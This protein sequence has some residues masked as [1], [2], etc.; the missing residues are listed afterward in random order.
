M[1][2]RQNISMETSDIDRLK[3][4][5]GRLTG[6]GVNGLAAALLNMFGDPESPDA[7]HANLCA[8]LSTYDL[9]RVRYKASDDEL[10]RH[11]H[12]TK[13]WDK[14]IW[15]IPIHRVEEEHWVLAAVDIDQQQ[16]LFFDSLG[17]RSRGWRRD[18][19]VCL[20]YF[21]YHAVN[22][23]GIVGYNGINY[24]NGR[25]SKPQQAPSSCING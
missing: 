5:T 3:S 12:C 6:F 18:I 4:R 20:P 16:I 11:L 9:V 7:V 13:Y 14:Q 10:W 1:D 19:R 21:V 2:G 22:A 15:L 24:T 8:V 23:H 17:V 25:A